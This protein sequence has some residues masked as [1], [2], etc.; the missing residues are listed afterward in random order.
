MS[1]VAR[2][3]TYWDDPVGDLLTYQCDPA[4]GLIKWSP[5][6]TSRSIRS[7]LYSQQGDT[8]KMATRTNN[9]LA[10]DHVNES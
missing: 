2:G 8:I 5:L 9:E 7:A 3:N 4:P 10:K 6:L 1:G